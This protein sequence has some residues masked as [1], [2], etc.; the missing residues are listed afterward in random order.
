LCN[1]L[2]A[3]A[4][5]NQQSLNNCMIGCDLAI[6]LPD[7][8][9]AYNALFDCVGNAT[10]T[11]NA[12]G[13]AELS[14]CATQQADALACIQTSAQSDPA[15]SQ[16]CGNYCTA[17]VAANCTAG[18]ATVD[19]CSTACSLAGVALPNCKSLWDG[20]LRCADGKAVTCDANGNPTA[21]GCQVDQLLFFLCAS[22]AVP[23]AAP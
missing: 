7:C 9:D 14:G 17:A 11:C 23:A 1:T 18:P 19:D 16:T 5:P 12:S 15:L 13:Q 3:A 2:D 4:C 8:T 21:S 20:Y 22:N 10:A 6:N